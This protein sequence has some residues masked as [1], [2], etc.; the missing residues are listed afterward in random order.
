MKYLLD[1]DT[2]VHLL[3][4][5]AAMQQRVFSADPSDLAIS[6][7]THAELCYGASWSAQPAANRRAVDAFAD[8]LSVLSL[9]TAVVQAYGEVKAMLR[10]QGQG[11]EDFDLLIAMTA[12]TN[13]LS[14]VTNNE[15]HFR[16]IPDLSFANWLSEQGR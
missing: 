8:T 3:R 10:R 4:G 5:H 15:Q 7:I 14:L 1:T 16:R 6:I 12:R 2:C 13:G 9:N 11:I